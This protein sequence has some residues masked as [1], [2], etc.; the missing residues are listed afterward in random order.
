MFPGAWTSLSFVLSLC[1]CPILIVWALTALKVVN[2]LTCLSPLAC[3]GREHVDLVLLMCAIRICSPSLRSIPDDILLY[4][5]G[6][7]IEWKCSVMLWKTEVG[8][9]GRSDKDTDYLSSLLTIRA[10]W[11]RNDLPL[12]CRSS[13]RWT[14]MWK[15]CS[16]AWPLNSLP[17]LCAVRVL[18]SCVI[19]YPLG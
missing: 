13:T 9:K 18:F 11:E 12:Q 16:I 6:L 3:E 15:R 19:N 10:V 4:W 7:G 5:I 1:L 17:L 8:T 2:A 14:I